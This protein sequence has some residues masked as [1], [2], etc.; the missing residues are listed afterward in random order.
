M[1]LLRHSSLIAVSKTVPA[2]TAV[3]FLYPLSKSDLACSSSLSK[4]SYWTICL[5]VIKK[6][7]FKSSYAAENIGINSLNLFTLS[8]EDL[9]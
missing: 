5:K 2:I 1:P 8:G 7:F 4:T 9:S 3:A 6:P